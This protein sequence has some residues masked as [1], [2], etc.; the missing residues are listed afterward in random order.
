MKLQC[1]GK[2]EVVKKINKLFGE[3]IH[4]HDNGEVTGV[5]CLSCDRM[6]YVGG[7]RWLH[8]K[9]LKEIKK[10]FKPVEE[11][12]E[13]VEASYKGVGDGYE[14]YMAKIV[15][16]PRGC[17]NKRLQS[18]AMCEHCYVVCKAVRYERPY[19]SLANG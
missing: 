17:Y 13:K 18:F 7:V 5:T 2:D 11:V 16:S 19:F 1:L 4:K 10:I 3:I 15:L 9:R 6:L 14:P 8:Q 12:P